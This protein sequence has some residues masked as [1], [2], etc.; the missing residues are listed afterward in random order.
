MTDE[1]FYNRLIR[2]YAANLDGPPSGNALADG[3]PWD[4]LTETDRA[5]VAAF[6]RNYISEE[7]V[8]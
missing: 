7:E 3:L 8:D 6:H 4:Q 2:P 5:E 1:Q